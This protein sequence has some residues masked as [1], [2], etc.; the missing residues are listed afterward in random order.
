MVNIW[1][2][3]DFSEAL[4]K[5]VISRS[6][7]N[8]YTPMCSMQYQAVLSSLRL[9]HGTQIKN[10]RCRDRRTCKLTARALESRHSDF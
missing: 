5:A 3:S 7:K 6:Q 9:T 10:P 1:G 8:A 4:A 2:V